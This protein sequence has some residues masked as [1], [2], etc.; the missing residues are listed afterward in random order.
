MPDFKLLA[1]FEQTFR[2]GPYLHR[3]SQIGNRIADYLID[4]LYDLDP[5]SQLHRDVD[6]GRVAL[7]PKGVSPGLKARRGDGSFGPI[8]P[9]HTPRL[10]A[11][12]TVP[13]AATSEVDIGAEVK[14]LAKA[15]I[16]QI[17]R[18][19]SDLC[20]QSAEFRV[21]SPDAQTVALVGI[22][23]APQYVSFEG[24]RSYLTGESGPHPV[25][26][27]DEAERR[28]LT[29]AASCFDELLILRFRATNL[30]PYEFNWPHEPQTR[31]RYGAM[32]ARI[33]R[34]YARA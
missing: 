16:K 26:E 1:K 3:N 24:D 17:D 28:I 20:R 19:I 5:T 30:P 11:G 33:V 15:M 7:N 32:L 14:I 9:G 27:A 13:I 8:V 18:V 34:A 2:D 22:N 6:N 10:Y 29:S 12:H 23:V 31:D 21:K 4:D 25:Q